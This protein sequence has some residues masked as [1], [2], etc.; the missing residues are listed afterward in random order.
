MKE[1]IVVLNGGSSSIKFSAFVSNADQDL[2][3][4]LHGQVDGIGVAP[5]FIAKNHGGEVIGDKKWEEFPDINYHN[6]L[7][8]LLGWL[9]DNLQDIQVRAVGHRVGHGG[10]TYSQPVKIEP[11]VLQNLEKLIPLVPLHQ[12]HNLLPIRTLLE[13]APHLIQV[14]C[15]DTAFH[16][17]NPVVA[18]NFALPRSL[19]E[20]GVRRYGFHGLSYEFIARQLPKFD[21]QAAKGKVV[22]AHLGSGASMCA[23]LA[24]KSITSTM[25]FS[26]LDG[27][28]MGTRP[29]NLDPGVILYLMREKEMD[30][31]DL[32]ELF[33][34]KSGLLG[35][36][37]ISNDMRVLLESEDSR[38]QEAIDLFVYRINRELGSLAA[39]LGGLDGLVFTAGIGE[40]APLIRDRV[41]EQAQWLGIQI[42]PEANRRGGP[43]IS[44]PDSSVKV[45]VI[46]TN[47]E[48]IIADHTRDLLAQENS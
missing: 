17:T 21:P 1:G 44:S 38:A 18:Q 3:L 14:A 31:A 43:L 45:W 20:E 27:V 24:G 15:F 12:P 46:P 33:Y 32:E 7:D 10:E 34:K 2:E 5:R 25:G 29:G 36:S 16:R 35:V 30:V 28:P 19:T 39:A 9:R 42:D 6:L 8:Y 13:L 40:H 4:K 26:A 11:Q 47:E 23:M 22:V 41:C 37:Q 48:F